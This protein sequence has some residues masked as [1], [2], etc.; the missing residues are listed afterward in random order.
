MPQVKFAPVALGDM[1]NGKINKSVRI[2]LVEM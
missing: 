1:N 2:D